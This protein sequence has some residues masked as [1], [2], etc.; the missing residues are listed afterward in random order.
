MGQSHKKKRPPSQKLPTPIDQPLELEPVDIKAEL[1]TMITRKYDLDY[2]LATLESK[3]YKLEASYLRD[4]TLKD[5]SILERNGYVNLIHSVEKATG[6]SDNYKTQNDTPVKQEINDITEDQ[7]VFSKTSMDYQKAI[8]AVERI[9]HA[10]SAETSFSTGNVS[11]SQ[12]PFSFGQSSVLKAMPAEV[13]PPSDET[14]TKPKSK[15]K[16]RR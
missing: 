9:T 1:D 12:S 15:K 7:R 2:S 4:H 3:I 6:L 11:R 13:N 14:T 5:G 10:M 16:R 8:E